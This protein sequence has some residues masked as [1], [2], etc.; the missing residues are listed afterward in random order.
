LP[1][2]PA[3]APAGTHEPAALPAAAALLIDG[4]TGRPVPQAAGYPHRVPYDPDPGGH[5][6][7][8]QPAADLRP[9]AWYRVVVTPFLR[10]AAGRSVRPAGWWFRTAGC[11]AVPG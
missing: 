9:C 5:V 2:V 8:V 7:A 1:Y 10:D 11:G 6:V 3:G 4:S